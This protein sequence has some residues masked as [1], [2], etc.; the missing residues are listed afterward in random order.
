MAGVLSG[1]GG[2]A[3]SLGSG[4]LFGLGFGQSSSLAFASRLP[5]LVFRL[6]FRPVGFGGQLQAAKAGF[7]VLCLPALRGCH[8]FCVAG[9]WFSVGVGVLVVVRRCGVAG[10]SGSGQ[11]VL[12][13]MPN[14]PVKGT[15][16]HS[17][18]QSQFFSQVSGFAVGHQA[19]SPLP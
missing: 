19:G 18:W 2:C 12:Y 6:H 8:P 17:G 5:C 7:G 3:V 10:C 1:I 11:N 14:K 4:S 9:W 16:R 13:P 15:A